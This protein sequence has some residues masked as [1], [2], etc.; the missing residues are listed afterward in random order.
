MIAQE[1]SLEENLAAIREI[2]DSVCSISPSHRSTVTALSRNNSAASHGEVP[3]EYCYFDFEDLLF[4][5]G[6]YKR[7][8]RT[9]QMATNSRGHTRS[10]SAPITRPN[11]SRPQPWRQSQV[12]RMP[13]VEEESINASSDSLGSTLLPSPSSQESESSGSLLNTTPSRSSLVGLLKPQSRL[14]GL[15]IWRLLGKASRTQMPPNCD[16]SNIICSNEMTTEVVAAVFDAP[17]LPPA[18][19]E[20][21]PY[22]EGTCF[23]ELSVK[24]PAAML[25]MRTLLNPGIEF[26]FV[27]KEFAK[28]FDVPIASSL[29]KTFIASLGRQHKVL[30]QATLPVYLDKLNKNSVLSVSFLIIADSADQSIMLGRDVWP[31]IDAWN[32]FAPFPQELTEYP[33]PDLKSEFQGLELDF[34]KCSQAVHEAAVPNS[35]SI[36]PMGI[37]A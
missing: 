10:Q 31:H 8:F 4:T 24:T 11:F 30:G 9:R 29:E 16:N 23:V 25:T 3:L 2:T 35:K 28:A 1:E 18:D 34:S 33:R 7:N 27:S 12:Y 21:I 22:H 36:Y 37:A 6:V 17:E 26:S 20:S 19:E 5:S 14:T 32:T 13:Q 15:G